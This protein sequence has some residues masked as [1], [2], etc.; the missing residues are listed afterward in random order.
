MG[1][2]GVHHRNAVPGADVVCPDHSSAIPV[3][4]GPPGRVDPTCGNAAGTAGIHLPESNNWSATRLPWLVSPVEIA[5]LLVWSF[6][7]LRR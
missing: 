2:T 3:A 5:I 1:T 6:T 4:S 7:A